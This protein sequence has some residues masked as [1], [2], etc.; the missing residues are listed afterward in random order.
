MTEDRPPACSPFT[1]HDRQWRDFRYVYPV[2]SRRSAGLS[3]GINLNPD[4]LC[5]FDC[6]YCQVDRSAEAPKPPVD[7]E[8]MRAELAWM[9]QHAV[10]GAIW[11]DPEFTDVP[12]Q[13]RRINDIAFSGNGEPTLCKQFD[14]A[15]EIAA[16]VKT[17]AGLGEVKLAVLTNATRL[18]DPMVRRGLSVLDRHRGEIW[19]KLDAGT[20]TYYRQIDRS[21]VPLERVL[22]NIAEAGRARPIVIQSM[23]ARLHGSAIGD[24][25]FSAY[26]DRLEGLICD[27]CDIR[28]VQL[29]TVA[30]RPA[31]AHV[32]PLA[33]AELDKLA[34]RLRR[35]LP[36]L[37]CDVYYGAT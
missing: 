37:P 28:L 23:F 29:Y 9:V 24:D 22:N 35:R 32:A 19:A 20:E 25:Y 12:T 4:Q 16:Q 33:D 3:I 10:G 13:L 17:E 15:C 31:E 8:A 26:L 6:V 14:R 34:E 18:D 11:S 27:G 1:R 36:E 21:S 5:N 7:L 30:R 2:I